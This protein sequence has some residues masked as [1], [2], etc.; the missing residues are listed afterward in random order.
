MLIK[1]LQSKKIVRTHFYC[2]IFIK[3]T[4][5]DNLISI[6]ICHYL[7]KIIALEIFKQ[8]RNQNLQRNNY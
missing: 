7:N 8:N 5:W 3:M 2:L 1:L 4:N 6:L